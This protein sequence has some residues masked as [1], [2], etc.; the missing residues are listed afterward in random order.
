MA[1]CGITQTYPVKAVILADDG[2]AGTEIDIGTAQTL[3]Q[4]VKL[5]EQQGFRV[6]DHSDGGQ[7]RFRIGQTQNWHHF[8]VTVYPD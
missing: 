6:R 3:G 2:L 4:A 7:S 1:R 5:A 8:V